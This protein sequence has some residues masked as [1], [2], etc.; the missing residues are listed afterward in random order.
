MKPIVETPYYLRQAE[1]QNLEEPDRL[2]VICAIYE[3][4]GEIGESVPGAD[5][6][7]EVQVTFGIEGENAVKARTIT[8]YT[9]GYYPIFILN[10]FASNVS[11][12]KFFEQIEESA[13][14]L[15]P[16][17]TG[18]A[19]IDDFIIHTPDAILERSFKDKVY[20]EELT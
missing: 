17:I 4:S 11:D 20:C 18:E 14:K 15:L 5:G 10:V 6:V 1:Q 16:T 7:R 19:G 12:E 8:Y 9:N 13:S 3:S 2:N